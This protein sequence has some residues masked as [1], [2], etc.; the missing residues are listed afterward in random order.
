MRSSWVVATDGARSRVREALGLRMA[1]TSYEGRYVIA[2]IHWPSDLPTERLV[3]FDP[4]SNPG[5][6]I[7][8]HR[9]PRPGPSPL[10]LPRH[11]W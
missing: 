10:R 8:M 3:W 11:R 4:V 2:D 5:S 7:I 9:Q 1:G 6:T